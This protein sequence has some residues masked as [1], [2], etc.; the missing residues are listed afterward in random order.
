MISIL[1]LAIGI[2]LTVFGASVPISEPHALTVK[3]V[4]VGIGFALFVLVGWATREKRRQ[5][6]NRPE[7][8][9]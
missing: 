6:K 5:K 9:R 1:T 2:S 4:L 7:E 8:R 3:A